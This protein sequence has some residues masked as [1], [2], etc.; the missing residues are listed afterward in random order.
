MSPLAGGDVRGAARADAVALRAPTSAD[1]GRVRE[2][3]EASGVFRPD[4]VAIALEVFDGAV[5]AP[6]KD[7]RAVG[8][9]ED[10]RLV[11]FAAFGPVPCTVATWDL[12]WIAVDPVLHGSGIGRTLMAHCEAAI[13]A[14]GGRLVVV[15]TSSRDDYGPT[16]AFYRRLRYH[17]HAAI[18]DY[19]APGDGLV[20]YTKSLAPSVNG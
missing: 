11:G 20:V 3:T 6:G 2:I 4:E 1:R 15:E 18:T 7:Y 19:Y 5:A 12:Y 16:R 9:Y 13:T 17:E 14:E 8:A 10:D